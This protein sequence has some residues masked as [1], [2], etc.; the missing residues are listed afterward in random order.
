MGA[1]IMARRPN[2]NQ[3]KVLPT[4]SAASVP[5]RS[6]YIRRASAPVRSASAMADSAAGGGGEGGGGGGGRRGGHPP[7][8]E[9]SAEGRVARPLG[10]VEQ[11]RLE[12]LRLA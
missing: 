8:E 4:N 12:P 10:P 2:F 11:R 3:P 1:S 6:P 5:A 7:A 9:A